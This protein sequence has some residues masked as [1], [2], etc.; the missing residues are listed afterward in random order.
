MGQRPGQGAHASNIAR[1]SWFRGSGGC[2]PGSIPQEFTPPIFR[3]KN[4]TSL[5]A[6][7]ISPL[8]S[9]G[10]RVVDSL[11][12]LCRLLRWREGD[13]TSAAHASLAETFPLPPFS[14]RPGTRCCSTA[15]RSLGAPRVCG[16]S[17]GRRR[18][19]RRKGGGRAGSEALRCAPSL[20]FLVP[21]QR[22]RA[23]SC[24]SKSAKPRPRH[25]DDAAA[26]TC[27]PS[28]FLP[29]LFPKRFLLLSLL[30]PLSPV[31]KVRRHVARSLSPRLFGCT[32]RHRSL[33]HLPAVLR[34][35]GGLPFVR[36]VGARTMVSLHTSHHSPHPQRF[37]PTE[38][39]HRS[40]HPNPPHPLLLLL[41][42]FLPPHLPH[43][44]SP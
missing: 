23:A 15:V 12:D 18:R 20:L 44:S 4:A 19:A 22:P 3:A 10:A 29:V 2:S 37:Q 40:H 32:R 35:G 43:S 27:S 9:R 5:R 38:H 16:P 39:P 41:L 28:Q 17:E 31:P 34:G 11:D 21:P 8:G 30:L 42:L 14:H 36:D 24:D 33:H 13:R 1:C 7:G 6:G 26:A 25:T